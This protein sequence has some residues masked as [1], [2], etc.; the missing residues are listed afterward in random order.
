MRIRSRKMLYNDRPFGAGKGGSLYGGHGSSP[1]DDAGPGCIAYRRM[2]LVSRFITGSEAWF[3]SGVV[4]T[5]AIATVADPIAEFVYDLPAEY[6]SRIAYFQVRTWADDVENLSDLAPL[7]VVLDADRNQVNSI[8][9]TAVLLDYELRDGGV[10]RLKFRWQRAVTGIQPLQFSAVRTA[11]PSSPAAA[12]IDYDGAAFVEIDTPALLDSS[13]Y[14]YKI[15]AING[16]TTKDVL[17]GISITADATG[18]SEPASGS[19][20]AW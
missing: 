13:A 10:V 6:A 19:A 18:P 8:D 2:R 20:A 17:T 7:R 5:L 9:G 3:G 14:T 15:T 1:T 4:K 12:T 16:S 11:G